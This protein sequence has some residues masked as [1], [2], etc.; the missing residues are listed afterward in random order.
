MASAIDFYFVWIFYG[1]FVKT[2][3]GELMREVQVLLYKDDNG[4]VPILEWLDK[5]SSK[6]QDKCAVRI[7]RLRDCGHELRRPETDYLRDGI[8]EL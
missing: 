8:Y 2:E 4:N 1:K 5:I 6:A 7:K 3:N